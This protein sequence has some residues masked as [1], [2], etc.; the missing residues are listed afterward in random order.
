MD[1]DCKNPFLDGVTVDSSA[2]FNFNGVTNF[3]AG[4]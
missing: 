3:I 1:K 2:P 4:W